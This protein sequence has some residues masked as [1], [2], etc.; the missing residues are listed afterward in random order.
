[1]SS[2]SNLSQVCWWSTGGGW[3]EELLLAALLLDAV[4]T[5]VEEMESSAMVGGLSP[6][7]PVEICRD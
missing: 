4:D 5:D 6:E 2:S 3:G 7:M 1:M